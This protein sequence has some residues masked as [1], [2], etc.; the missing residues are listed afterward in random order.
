MPRPK[1]RITWRVAAAALAVVLA[2]LPVSTFNWGLF[3][4]ATYDA[5]TGHPQFVSA[6]VS[7]TFEAISPLT[8]IVCPSAL[9]AVLAIAAGLALFVAI[10]GRRACLSVET[11]CPECDRVLR[12]LSEPAC[13]SCG[14]RL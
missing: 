14:T 11:R 13:P 3:D 5:K 10:G 1:R 9:E 7:E 12:N 8:W 2:A 4:L 6:P